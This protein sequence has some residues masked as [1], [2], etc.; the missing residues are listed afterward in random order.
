MYVLTIYRIIDDIEIAW[1]QVSEG[2]RDLKAAGK[3]F[4]LYR[5]EAQHAFLNSD[6][7]ERYEPTAAKLAWDRCLDFF[8]RHLA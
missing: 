3:S 2:E 5:Y 7:K 8:R 4:E 1:Q 6:R